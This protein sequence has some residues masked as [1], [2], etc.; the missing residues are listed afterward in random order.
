MQAGAFGRAAQLLAQ[1]EKAGT[2]AGG[3]VGSLRQEIARRTAV[4]QIVEL[5]RLI[6]TRISQGQLIEPAGDSAKSYLTAL[7]ERGGASIADDVARLT[8]LYQKRTITEAHAAMAS[9]AWTQADAWI[10]ELRATKGGAAIAQPLQ[11]ELER[12]ALDA[13][14]AEQARVVSPPPEPVAVS[15]AVATQGQGGAGI[16]TP[17]HLAKPLKVD[18]PRRATGSNASGWVMVE[19]D[20]DGTGRVGGVRVLDAQPKGV[21]DAA[22][23]TAVE[24]ATFA[25]ATATDGSHPGMTVSMRVRFQLDDQH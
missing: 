22:A 2:I 5:E 13:R 4:A 18:Y 17:A 1:G 20:V 23:R 10:A 19:V 14:A 8:D 25:P 12:R 3:D 21:F 24:R 6:Q 9:G 11:K 16:V 7:T 15:A